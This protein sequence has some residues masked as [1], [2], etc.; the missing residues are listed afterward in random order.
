MTPPAGSS[1]LEAHLAGCTCSRLRRLTRRVTAVYDHALAGVGMRV[2]QFSLLAHLRGLEGVPMTEL[3]ERLDM[4]RT[5]LTR[6]LGPLANAG[7]VVVEPS[8]D[9]A[10][11]RLVRITP[12]GVAQWRAARSHWR[13]AQDEVRATFGDATLASLHRL[14]DDHLPLFRPVSGAGGDTE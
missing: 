3:A 11:R 7:W 5:T 4:D 1:D 14:L 9:D 8:P 13:R 10:R 12:E 2:T 6:N